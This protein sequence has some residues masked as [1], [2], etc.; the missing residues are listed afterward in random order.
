MIQ[1]TS[2]FGTKTIFKCNES[3]FFGHIMQATDVFVL[4]KNK[5]K[6]NYVWIDSIFEAQNICFGSEI[7]GLLDQSYHKCALE[8]WLKLWK[9]IVELRRLRTLTCTL[10]MF[11]HKV[12]AIAFDFISLLV[13]K[14]IA[15]IQD[16]ILYD[17]NFL[18]LRIYQKIWD[19]LSFQSL[20][21][22]N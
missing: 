15:A 22:K 12:W 3:S 18:S 19:I 7:A 20:Y 6:Q 11:W 21:V 9:R 10:K 8:K 14:W 13:L 2:F 17:V 5:S 4:R 1:E 16:I